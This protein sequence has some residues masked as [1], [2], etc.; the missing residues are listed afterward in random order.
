MAFVHLHNHSHY[1]LL[2]GLPK[3]PDILERAQELAMN[4][5]ALTDHGSMYGV[6]EF[7]QHAIKKNIRPIIGLEAYVARNALTDKRP[8]LDDRP[9]HL[10]LL[11]KTTEGYHNLITLTSIAHTQGYYYK[12]RIDLDVLEKYSQGLIALS[13]CLNGALARAILSNQPH[14]IDEILTRYQRIFGDNYYLELQPHHA[15][16]KQPI[17]NQA[18]KELSKTKGI[19]LV[20]TNDAHYART[21]DAESQDILLCIQTKKKKSDPDRLTF[22]SENCS[23]RSED[24]MK[25]LFPDLEDACERTAA[26]ASECSVE[27]EFG[28]PILSHFRT[29]ENAPVNAYLRDLCENGLAARYGTR[30]VAANIRERLEYELGVITKAGFESY[31]LIVQDF[32]NWA[33]QEGIVVGPGRGS[34]AGSIVSYLLNITDLDP[35]K[36]DLLFERFLNPERISMPDIDLD[37]ADTRRDEVLHYVEEKYGKDHVAQ[38]ITFGTMAA[39]AAVRDVGRVLGLSYGYCDRIAKLIPMFTTLGEALSTNPELK[40][41]YDSD[42]DA[43]ALLDSAKKLEGSVRHTSTHACG[44]VITKEPLTHYLPIQFA[45]PDDPTII[46]QYSLHPV[47][48]LGLL[49]MDFLGLKNLTIIENAI[50]IIKKT[51]GVAIDIHSIPLD[52]KKTFRLFQRGDTTGVFQLESSG[53]KRYLRELKPTE[54]EDIIAMVSLYRPGPMELIPDYIAG[55]HGKKTITYLHPKLEPILKKTYGIA[56]YQEQVMEIARQIAGFTLGEAD[57]L[58]KAI[59]KKIKELLLEQREKFINGAIKNNVPSHIAERLWDFTEPFASYGF[60]RSHAACYAMIAYQTAYLKAHFPAQFMAALLTSD[61]DNTDRIAIEVEE[62]RT[63]GIHV[64]PPDINESFSTFTVVKESVAEGQPR[65][66]FGLKAVK[67]LGEH[68]VD[69]IIA[70]RRTRGKFQNLEDFLRRVQSK[71]LNKKSLESL[72]KSGGLTPLAE[73]NQI[74]YNMEALLAY[75]KN[76]HAATANGQT[77]LF[78]NVPSDAAP[79]L[80][81]KVTEP[82]RESE[83]LGWEKELLGLYIS[84]HPLAEYAA[85]L[86]GF[87][88][89]ADLASRGAPRQTAIA[90]ILQQAKRVVTKNGDVMVFGTL[91]DASGQIEVIVFPKLYND[92]PEVWQEGSVVRVKGKSNTRDSELKFIAEE[93]SILDL[94]QLAREGKI[95]QPT[96]LLRIT[97][98]N[99]ATRDVL[100]KLRACLDEYPG[101]HSVELV[102]HGKSI[103]THAKTSAEPKILDAIRGL[104]CNAEMI[105]RV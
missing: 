50:Y 105:S 36:Y 86:R 11:A 56:V 23:I 70:E 99:G 95:V 8:K 100:E 38:I 79:K 13:G 1:S 71:D 2:D 10:T 31:F 72:A 9:Y 77:N 40:N 16:G 43:R 90:G 91:E 54:L 85:H 34:A 74:L 22:G 88:P 33:K 46:T 18:L 42:P 44:V 41:I 45:A 21:S 47:E 52:D 101:S 67:N 80:T 81:L 25:S 30:D 24:E 49:K 35:L 93:A 87:T 29:P 3:I 82:A 26:I 12:P 64:L 68:I 61:Q 66:R 73:P 98:P 102:I 76:H 63:M 59:G 75:A 15:E 5:I 7:Y 84:G 51:A 57:V 60:N 92:H 83:K 6:I 48:D 62:C 53:M 96:E 89:I 104:S 94:E 27:I 19:P 32:V 4:A 20:V 37:F 39:R 103:M 55:K 97:V 69:A 14:A 78:Q 65:I 28:K 58:R 17:V